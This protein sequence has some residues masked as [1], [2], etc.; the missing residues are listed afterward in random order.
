M[1]RIT[2]A[3]VAERA[4]VSKAT[5]SHVINETRF[6]EDATKSRVREAIDALGYRPNVAARS[7]TTQR[8]RIIGLIISDVTN[9]F[10]GELTRGIE[11]ALFANGYSL[12]LCNTNEVLEREE[13]YIDILLRQGVDG[14]IAAATSQDWDALNEAAKLNIPIVMLD[15]TFENADSPYVGVNNSQGAYLGTRHL[16]ER[17]YREIGILSGFQ[18]LST[19]RERLAGFEQALAEAKLPLRADW[20]IDSPL[21]IEDG[22]RAMQQLMGRAGRPGAVFISNNL[23]SL[24]ALMGLREMELVCPTDI[25]IVGFDDHPWARVSDP[26]LTVVRQPTYAIGETAAQKVLQALNDGDGDASSALFDC[27]LVMRQSC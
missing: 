2:M 17:G 6:V 15:R 8:T 24:G 11:D 18:R 4:G 9:T 23:L 16:I 7:L 20:R 13:Y 3:D 21:T 25:A 14:I 27:Q 1:R 19:M 5:V 10:F 12:M 26:P 22:K